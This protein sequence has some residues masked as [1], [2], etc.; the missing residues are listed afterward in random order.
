MM[1]CLKEF[2]FLLALGKGCVILSTHPWTFHIYSRFDH[3]LTVA[4]NKSNYDIVTAKRNASPKML[5]NLIDK[6]HACTK[7]G[8]FVFFVFVFYH[9]LLHS[10]NLGLVVNIGQ[11]LFGSTIYE[12]HIALMVYMVEYIF[13]PVRQYYE[14]NH[15][16]TNCQ[17]L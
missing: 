17:L 8:F 16:N 6:Y 2:L 14:R 4:V 7:L 13:E 12:D 15:D 11:N 10:H 5:H 9:T 3:K 1:I